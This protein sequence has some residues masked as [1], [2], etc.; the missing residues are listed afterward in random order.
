MPAR[1]TYGRRSSAKRRSVTESQST[2]TQIDF[3]T[4]VQLSFDEYFDERRG[5]L[6]P[7][8]SVKRARNEVRDSED[9]TDEGPRKKTRTISVKFEILDSEEENDEVLSKS[10][11]K[12]RKR[13]PRA[14]LDRKR[15]ETLTQ[16]PLGLATNYL[17]A[18]FKM[19]KQ[20]PVEINGELNKYVESRER[21]MNSQND[22]EQRG[23]YYISSKRASP[24]VT[25]L[26]RTP[27]K[28]KGKEEIPSS[29]SPADSPLSTLRTPQTYRSPLTTRSTCTKTIN[30]PSAQH[31]ISS[32]LRER[33]PNV[34]ALSISPTK[35][36]VRQFNARMAEAVKETAQRRSKLASQRK[37]ISSSVKTSQ[38]SES[39]DVENEALQ[40]IDTCY[41]V[42]PETQAALHSIDLVCEGNDASNNVQSSPPMKPHEN[43]ERVSESP[44]KIGSTEKAPS[45]KEKII[46]EP[47]RHIS[48]SQYPNARSFWQHEP[49]WRPEPTDTYF[50]HSREDNTQNS[51]SAQL[52]RETQAHRHRII[53]SPG[54]ES[55][56][57]PSSQETPKAPASIQATQFLRSSVDRIPPSQVSTVDP[58]LEH[59]SFRS[60]C[61]PESSHS[62]QSVIVIP[63][64]PSVGRMGPPQRPEQRQ[65]MTETQ[66]VRNL[67][68]SLL[69][70]D[71]DDDPVA[72]GQLVNA[73]LMEESIGMPPPISSPD[74]GV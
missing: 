14:D 3:L 45:E 63:S 15:Q 39:A 35:F 22:P 7:R 51:A 70:F 33:S 13:S 60:Q 62:K 27:K 10:S 32:P 36:H 48:S 41:E 30:S 58:S 2:L 37:V 54:E 65:G 25:N 23:D 34:R 73:T 74:E 68:K 57:V 24:H 71:Y 64:S 49:S 61:L 59:S 53:S 28:F 42:S 56:R 55:E 18:E 1:R 67:R 31:V 69:D 29:Q 44:V 47:Q 21:D 50:E 38:A 26:L 6:H 40:Q 16:M 43:D 72:V 19:A 66:R 17:K 20:E 52:I 4:P 8:S 11:Q 5:D 46:E 12:S 9:D